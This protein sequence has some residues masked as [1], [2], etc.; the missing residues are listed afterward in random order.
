MGTF[1]IW[2]DEDGYDLEAKIKWSEIDAYSE[3]GNSL[4]P[5]VGTRVP[6]TWSIYSVDEGGAA[7]FQGYQYTCTPRAPWMGANAFQYVDVKDISFAAALDTLVDAVDV[8]TP[9]EFSMMRN[10]PNP[11]NPTT[12]LQFNIAASANVNL[13]IYNLNGELV[14]SVLNN[15]YRTPGQYEMSVDMSELP[16][17]VYVSVLEQGGQVQ[18]SKMML[19]K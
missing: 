10:Y 7:S 16:S 5:D 14:K 11:F 9:T 1:V 13:N 8:N 6:C 19:M 12:M 2:P 15:A 3:H 18:T 4:K 17:G